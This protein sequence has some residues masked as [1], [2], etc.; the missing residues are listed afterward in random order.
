MRGVVCDI[1]LTLTRIGSAEALGQA[2]GLPRQV[3]AAHYRDYHAGRLT[4]TQLLDLWR[5]TGNATRERMTAAFAGVPLRDG[6]ARLADALRA[7]R[8]PLCLITSSAQLFADLMVARLG[9][10]CGY[11]NGRLTF[12]GTGYLE[13]LDFGLDTQQ[14][15]AHHLA[16]FCR[17]HGL[18]AQDVIAV[19]NGA[20][21]LALFDATSRGVL[22]NPNPDAKPAYSN[23][24]WTTVSR[25]SDVIPLLGN[26]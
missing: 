19:G 9:A 20:N 2:L 7:R 18:A 21:D 11:G 6:A 14:L 25:L 24:A 1:D 22:L 3:Q 13:D 4:R 10:C 8:I 5:D 17:E 15:K 23:R 16:Q 12:D 26:P